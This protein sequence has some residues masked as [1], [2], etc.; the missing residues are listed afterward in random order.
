M[1]KTTS[2]SPIAP[3][4]RSVHWNAAEAL[5]NQF[6]PNL[7]ALLCIH[8]PLT[9]FYLNNNI[10]SLSEGLALVL[11]VVLIFHPNAVGAIYFDQ[12]TLMVANLANWNQRSDFCS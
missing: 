4:V 10:V 9:Y 6:P 7:A 11:E 12:T 8:P 1:W 2:P 5:R 3:L